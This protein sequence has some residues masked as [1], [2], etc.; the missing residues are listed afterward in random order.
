MAIAPGNSSICRE[1]MVTAYSSPVDAL[2]GLL[3]V[4]YSEV[5][6]KP[7]VLMEGINCCRLLLLTPCHQDTMLMCA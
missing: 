2:S 4:M 3:L 6:D 7:V 1:A 5:F